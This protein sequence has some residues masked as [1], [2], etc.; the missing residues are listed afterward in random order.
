MGPLSGQVTIRPIPLGHG[1]RSL[2]RSEAA[3]LR[4]V[5]AEV[6]GGE[7]R[8]MQLASVPRTTFQT[9]RRRAL[10]AGWV[11][12]RIVPFLSPAGIERVRIMLTQPFAEHHAAALMALR[13]DRSTIF[14]ASSFETIVAVQFHASPAPRSRPPPEID[15]R[16]IRRSWTVQVTAAEGAVPAFYDF[17]GAWSLSVLGLPPISYPQPLRFH[18]PVRGDATHRGQAP[19]R[20]AFQRFLAGPAGAPPGGTGGGP[21]EAIRQRRR[22]RWF[23]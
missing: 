2:T 1:M 4:A 19:T 14:L 5:L 23:L 16:W 6:P 11:R 18:D 13:D 17:E 7:R 3:V 10:Q 21:W 20:E 15:E 8:R 12:D 9:I 22:E